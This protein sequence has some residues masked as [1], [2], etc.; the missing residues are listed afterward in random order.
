MQAHILAHFIEDNCDV[1]T[2]FP[3]LGVNISGGHTQIV[4]CEIILIWK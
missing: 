3:F 4:F 2:D 1:K